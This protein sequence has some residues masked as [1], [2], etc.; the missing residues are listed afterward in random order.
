MN[1]TN[2][3]VTDN[4]T[5]GES[6]INDL[7]KDAGIIFPLAN[8]NLQNATNNFIAAKIMTTHILYA[9]FLKLK[10]RICLI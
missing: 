5:F 6:I 7:A 9:L 3:V 8:A 2:K 4:I 1:S 10:I